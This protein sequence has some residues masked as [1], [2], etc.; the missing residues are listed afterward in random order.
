M[1][2]ED[3]DHEGLPSIAFP[4]SPEAADLLSALTMDNFADNL[5]LSESRAARIR[6]E[7]N[8][9]LEMRREVLINS[10]CC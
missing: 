8:E 10:K 3:G 4:N 2:E 7:T 1:D 6:Q 9:R 5:S